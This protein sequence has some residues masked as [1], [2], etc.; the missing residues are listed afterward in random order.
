MFRE[1]EPYQFDRDALKVMPR[2]IQNVCEAIEDKYGRLN[3]LVF[4]AG[5]YKQDQQGCVDA[6]C[7]EKHFDERQGS[8]FVHTIDR[9]AIIQAIKAK[10]MPFVPCT[11]NVCIIYINNN[12]RDI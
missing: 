9:Q 6:V 4:D 3:P 10:G 1:I 11:Y 12:N 7:N 5:L 2:V 8:T